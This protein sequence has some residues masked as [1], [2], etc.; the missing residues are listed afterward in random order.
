MKHN[1][2]KIAFIGTSYIVLCEPG[3][4]DETFPTV[5]DHGRYSS[6]M[7]I[8]RALSQ[9]YPEHTLYNCSEGGHGPD[10]YAKRVHTL[11]DRYDPDV[12]VI[13]IT[14]GERYTLHFNDEYYFNY[15]KHFPIQIWKG[16]SPQNKDEPFRYYD[17]PLLDTGHG[18]LSTSDLNDMWSEKGVRADFTQNEWFAFKRLV[19]QLDKGVHAR[20]SDNMAVYKLIDHYLKNKGKEVHWFRWHA[21]SHTVEIPNDLHVL[22]DD[23]P[24]IEW[25]YYRKFGKQPPYRQQLITLGEKYENHFNTFCYDNGSHLKAEHMIS[26]SEYFDPLFI[27]E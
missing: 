5:S 9:R 12:F 26:F 25:E 2:P 4:Q 6:K 8:V 16:G 15:D 17:K 11:L 10:L 22:R 1:T 3:Y 13:E 7:N 20:H 23:T 21:D 19:S 24:M 18:F 14:D 27:N